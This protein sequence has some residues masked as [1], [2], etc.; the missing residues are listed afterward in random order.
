MRLIYLTSK[1]YPASTADHIYILQ[2]ARGFFHV[3]REDFLLVVAGNRSEP[4]RSSHQDGQTSD[5]TTASDD[6]RNLPVYRVG[7]RYGRFR[8]IFY[9]FWLPYFIISHK[10]AGHSTVF[11]SNDPNLLLVLIFWRI[12]FY[13]RIVSDWHMLFNDW[14]DRFI[15]Q[16]SDQLI[17]TSQKLKNAMIQ[18]SGIRE[19]TTCVAYGGINLALYQPLDQSAARTLLRLPQDKY[20]VAYIGF[21]KTLG[22][23]K[24]VGTMIEALPLLPENILM[25]FV[26]GSDREI[27]E[28]QK[29]ADARHV[30]NRCIFIGKKKPTELPPY[31]QAADLL[32]IPYP[33]LPHFRDYGFPM[34]VYEYMASRRPIVYSKLELV[35]EVIGDCAFGF[36]PGSMQDFARAVQ[37][38]ASHPDQ[39]KAYAESAYAKVQNYTWNRKAEQIADFITSSSR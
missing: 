13:Y 17:T 30:G 14:R 39:A 25:L 32:S 28:Y 12:V 3:L 35:E 6:F 2:L 11:F 27:T 29:F 4:V 15:M 26:G 7:W 36:I 20:I 23:E 33:D 5:H 19:E 21:F 1:S 22:M 10:H 18:T 31:E 38:A 9:F 24:G 8:T 34:K 16:K 37:E